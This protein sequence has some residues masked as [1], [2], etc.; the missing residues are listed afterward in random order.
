MLGPTTPEYMSLLSIEA[1]AHLTR[2]TIPARGRVEGF[3]AGNHR[4]PYL[5]SSTEFAE[6][7][8]YSPGDD[9]RNLD[10]RVYAKQDRYCVKQYDDETNLRA[11]ILLDSSAS[12][13]FRGTRASSPAGTQLSK[14]EYAKHIAA[15]LA[16]LFIRQ[17]DAVGLMQYDSRLRT[18]LPAKGSNSHLRELLRVLY[19]AIPEHASDAPSA[20][21]QAAG[22]LRRRGLVI[23]ISDFL[24]DP[25]ELLKSLHH[26]RYRKHE[27]IVLQVLSEEEL[28]FP[29]NDSCEFRDLEDIHDAIDLDPAAIRKEYLRQ[30]TNFLEELKKNCRSVPADYALLKTTTPYISALSDYLSFRSGGRK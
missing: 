28:T 27:I 1:Q 18:Q 7:R 30:F 3:K 8:E 21:H 14:F 29:Y 15:S 22:R 5:G 12:M 10:W 20:I 17:G 11:T 16:Y 24:A 23:L 6:H 9:P 13:R 2:L 19:A 26:L 4:S 25:A